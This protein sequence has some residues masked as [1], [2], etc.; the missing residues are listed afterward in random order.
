MCYVIV[1]IFPPQS[2]VAP[3]GCSMQWYAPSK[4]ER[5]LGRASKDRKWILSVPH[6]VGPYGLDDPHF[7]FRSNQAVGRIHAVR[8]GQGCRALFS[9]PR[10]GGPGGGTRSWQMASRPFENTRAF[11]PLGL[12]GWLSWDPLEPTNSTDTP[13]KLPCQ[14][15]L[16]NRPATW[17]L[18]SYPTRQCG[19][20]PTRVLFRR[21]LI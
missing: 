1:P 20:S 17:P 15:A 11:P 4:A 7:C 9:T 2:P 10:G 3:A 6:V 14:I 12:L 19:S 5:V 16:P 13:A 18:A 21:L 8:R